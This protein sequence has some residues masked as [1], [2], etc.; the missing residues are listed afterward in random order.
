MVF[1]GLWAALFG[2]IIGSFLNVVIH[3]LPKELS[4]VKPRSFCPSCNH[5]IPWYCNIPLL[6]FLFLRGRCSNCQIKISWR[7]FWVELLTALAALYIARTTPLNSM[8][9]LLFAFKLSVFSSLLALL[10]ID[11]DHK[12]LPNELNL[13]LAVLMLIYALMHYNWQFWL[14]GAAIGF[15]FPLAVTWIFY[16]VRGEIGLGGGDIKLYSVLGIYLGPLGIIHNIFLSCMLGSIIGIVL[17]LAKR[18][19][20][21][22][23]IPF[24]PAIIIVAMIQ[25]FTP[26]LLQ[27][28]LP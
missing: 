14:L 16:L 22:D 5:T 13:Y 9:F 21:S 4:I 18:I 25:I 17:L 11:L 19:S 7:Y 23:P 1:I 6:S 10:F 15:L 26:S 20:R 2:A 3:R 12:I 8:F 28:L 27:Q 24:G